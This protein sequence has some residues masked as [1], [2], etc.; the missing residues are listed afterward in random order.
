MKR[1]K[2][3]AGKVTKDGFL[4]GDSDRCREMP[5]GFYKTYNPV[6]HEST[7]R[8]TIKVIRDGEVYKSESVR[9][10]RMLAQCKKMDKRYQRQA[11]VTSLLEQ[12]K[13]CEPHERK[14]VLD[15]LERAMRK[16]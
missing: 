11:I 1:I 9:L 5:R 10:V 16:R 2:S 6:V 7:E 8:V 13:T 3:K 4:N 12:V 15:A 14:A